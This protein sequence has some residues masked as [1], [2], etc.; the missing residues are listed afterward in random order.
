MT[1][2]TSSN[3]IRLQPG[4]GDDQ[5]VCS[6]RAVRLENQRESYEALSYCWVSENNPNMIIC[7]GRRLKITT[8]LFHALRSLRLVNKM[9]TLWLHTVNNLGLL[10]RNQGRLAEAEVMYKR[11][12]AGYEKALG[13]A[14]AQQWT[15]VRN[16]IS[17][18]FNQNHAR[19]PYLSF[20]RRD[21][22]G[23]D[24]PNN[25]FSMWKRKIYITSFY[26]KLPLRIA[27]I[28]LGVVSLSQRAQSYGKLYKLT[29]IGCTKAISYLEQWA[30]GK[31]NWPRGRPH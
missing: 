21:T 10:Y 8:N 6:I 9:R 31:T 30:F 27:H 25:F 14:P 11:S 7:N 15:Q 23:L 3:T 24:I 20:L 16:V 19:T 28:N 22:I 29:Q 17:Y 4:M 1:R 2:T 26:K 5:L 13:T 12:L 18:L